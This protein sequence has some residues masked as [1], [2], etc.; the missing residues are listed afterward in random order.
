MKKFVCILISVLMF[1]LPVYSEDYNE[2]S[3]LRDYRGIELPRGSLIPVISLQNFSTLTHDVGSKVEFI[4]SSDMYLNEINI[5]PKNTKFY[6]YISKINEP[7]V[8]THAAM[9]VKIVKAEFTDGFEIPFKAEIYTPNGNM[10]GGGM[11][12]PAN[13][14]KKISRR[15]GFYKSVGY[16]PGATRKMGEHIEVSAGAD[17]LIVLD[18][19]IYITHTVTN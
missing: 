3:E 13:Y 1:F 10:I 14:V 17:M 5:I 7:I 19:P 8:G 11:T 2:Y 15:Q 6:G 12:E 16:V 18:V 9:R 4:C